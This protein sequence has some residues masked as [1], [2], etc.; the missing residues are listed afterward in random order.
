MKWIPSHVMESM[1]RVAV[2][3]LLLI[4]VP[5]GDGM[6]EQKS[7]SSDAVQVF[8]SPGPAQQIASTLIRDESMK[9]VPGAIVQLWRYPEGGGAPQLVDQAFANGGG[10]ADLNDGT[11][12]IF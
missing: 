4:I 5:I 10:H 6:R 7:S 8:Q 11:L 12:S 1:M 3:S 9:P 2:V